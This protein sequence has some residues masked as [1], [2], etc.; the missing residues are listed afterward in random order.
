MDKPTLFPLEQSES[1]Y[2]ALRDLRRI[3]E[4][5]EISKYLTFCGYELRD[6]YLAEESYARVLLAIRLV[7][8]LWQG[9]ER[10]D[11]I[12]VPAGDALNQLLDW[13]HSILANE[14]DNPISRFFYTHGF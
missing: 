10:L 14:E 8:L 2:K 12:A 3:A 13:H 7:R 11:W 6:D 9:V 1:V 4:G 5:V